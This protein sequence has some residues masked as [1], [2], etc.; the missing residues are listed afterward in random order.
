MKEI[1]DIY[2]G[3]MNNGAHFTYVSNLLARAEGDRAVSTN[4]AAQVAALKA[5][6]EQEDADLKLSR[7]SMLSDEI[8][9][10]DAKRD[11]FYVGYKKA[12]QG[13][14]RLPVGAMANAAKVLSQHIKDYAID[15]KMQLDRE[16]GMLKN[17]I[18]DLEG[19]YKQQVEAL[20]L[21]EFVTCMKEANERV[22]RLLDQRGNEQLGTTVGALKASRKATDEACRMLVK[23]V[24]ALALVEGEK[25]Y[26]AFI[27]RTNTEIV[28]YKREVLGQASAPA[29]TGGSGNTGGNQGGSSGGNTG[30]GSDGGDAMVGSIPLRPGSKHIGNPSPSATLGG[31]GLP[32]LKRKTIKK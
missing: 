19:T 14:L 1:S 8:A 4:A 23:M 17:F 5:A 20:S 21:G 31:G 2:L 7:K 16:T 26:A 3:R 10:A 32:F 15:P 27:D 24:N 22:N 28:R 9:A 29:D 13:F 12:V 25:D 30:G 18:A 11:D 6:V